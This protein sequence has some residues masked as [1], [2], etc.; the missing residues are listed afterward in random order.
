MAGPKLDVSS[1]N[2]RN[3][4]HITTCRP[5]LP[6]VGRQQAVAINSHSCTY[7]YIYIYIH[8]VYIYI[9]LYIYIY[10]YYIY[11]Y[12]YVYMHANAVGRQLV[13]S[14]VEAAGSL[15]PDDSKMRSVDAV[16]SILEPDLGQ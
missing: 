12:I 10:T 16:L 2:K 4:M 3:A 7:I 13:N 6:H 15:P 11:I 5:K 14:S 9:S 8:I 1:K